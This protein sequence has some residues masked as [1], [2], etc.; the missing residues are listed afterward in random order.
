MKVAKMKKDQHRKIRFNSIVRFLSILTFGIIG[1]ILIPLVLEEI[2]MISH[3][4]IDKE[5]NRMGLDE[6]IPD[7]P[8][9]RIRSFKHSWS[10][11][12]YDYTL[13]LNSP[14]STTAITKIDSLCQT[15]EGHLRWHFD[16]KKGQYTMFLWDITKDYND[17]LMITPGE[18]VVKFVYEPM[19][20]LQTK[21]NEDLFHGP[22]YG[23]E[24]FLEHQH[25]NNNTGLPLSK[26]HKNYRELS[27]D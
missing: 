6:D 15:Y 14:I 11:S 26:D 25:N 24:S 12:R 2:S 1:L 27:L 5:L 8:S 22:I 9:Y 21:K 3:S 19:S 16:E 17:F 7:F 23:K 10:R 20:R 18:N 13:K 4:F